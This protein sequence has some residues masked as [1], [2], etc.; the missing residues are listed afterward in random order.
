[1]LRIHYFASVR[2]A[3]GR[4]REQIE[5]PEDV[6]TVADLVR[7]LRTV[8]AVFERMLGEQEQVLVAVNQAVAGDD[9]AIADGDEIAFFPPMSGG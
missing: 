4:E 1:M 9:G 2:E 6:A 5:M 7:H 3:V 8:D